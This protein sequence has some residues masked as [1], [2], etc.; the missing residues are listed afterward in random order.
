M[1]G[2]AGATSPFINHRSEIIDPPMLCPW[3]MHY[4]PED[5]EY[6]FDDELYCGIC[7]QRMPTGQ[8]DWDA[9]YDQME[10]AWYEHIEREL[11][12]IISSK[13]GLSPA[14]REQIGK[15]IDAYRDR[16]LGVA[17]LPLIEAEYEHWFQFACTYF[18]PT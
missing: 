6:V 16:R 13:S 7:A 4:G 17:P 10:P 2:E 3:C 15:A 9:A 11:N 5:E 8:S 1:I 18:A 14:V 12:K